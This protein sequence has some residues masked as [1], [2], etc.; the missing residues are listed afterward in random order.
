VESPP[1]QASK[2]NED[3]GV[4]SLSSGVQSS[5]FAS[6]YRKAINPPQKVGLYAFSCQK[7]CKIYSFAHEIELKWWFCS[8][9]ILRERFLT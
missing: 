7:L 4:Y 6:S 3:V 8:L 2:K 1:E 5:D 9:F